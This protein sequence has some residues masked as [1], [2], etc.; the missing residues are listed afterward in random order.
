MLRHGGDEFVC[1]LTGLGRTETEE[2]FALV[3]SD[4]GDRGR[5]TAGVVEAA[6]HEDAPALLAR[7]DAAL[8]A[9]PA[10]QRN[11]PGS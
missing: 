3:N 1:V 10:G 9:R 4:L 6:Q 8:F 5:V 2:R 11:A 7:V